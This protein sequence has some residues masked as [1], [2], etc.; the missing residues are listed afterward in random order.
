MVFKALGGTRTVGLG[1]ARCE[2][3]EWVAFTVWLAA[4]WATILLGG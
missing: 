1:G 4:G 2:D 3:E